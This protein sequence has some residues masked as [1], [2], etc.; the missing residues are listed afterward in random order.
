[1]RSSFEKEKVRLIAETRRQSQIELDTAVK[2]AKS[3]QWCANCNQEAQFY[4]CWNTAYCDYPCQRAHWA[5]H[6]AVC[7]QHRTQDNNSNEDNRLQQAPENL[8][9][10]IAAPNLAAAKQLQPSRMYTQEQ[11][12][13]K[14]SIIMSM[15]EDNSGNQTMK[16]VGTYK[17][18]GGPNQMSPLIINKQIMSSEET[19][20]KVVTS[21]GYLIVGASNSTNSTTITPARRATAIQYIS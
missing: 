13:Q 5:T 14:A 7:A 2:L 9:K 4:C 15:V 1:M 17:P 10:T 16:C 12:P 8:P 3:K 21:G 19:A 6:Y 20:K 18:P 11:A